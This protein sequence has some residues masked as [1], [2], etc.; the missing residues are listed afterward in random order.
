M[1]QS[2]KNNYIGFP[3]TK[4]YILIKHA[5]VYLCMQKKKQ[6]IVKSFTL[7]AIGT[8]LF[9]SVLLQNESGSSAAMQYQKG[10]KLN[11]IDD[12]NYICE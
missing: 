4:R 3:T 10:H 2:F 5:F 8:Q 11:E 1:I 9:R 6:C 7:V 12:N